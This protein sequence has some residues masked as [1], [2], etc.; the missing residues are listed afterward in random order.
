[1]VETLG[2]SRGNGDASSPRPRSEAKLDYDFCY[3]SQR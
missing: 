1:M 2:L 3:R